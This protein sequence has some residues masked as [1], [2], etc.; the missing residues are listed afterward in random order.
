MQGRFE[1]NVRE[2]RAFAAWPTNDNLTLIVG[3]WPCAEFEANKKDVEEN[4]LKMLQLAP[5]FAARGQAANREERF[6]GAAVANYFR[7]PF[8]PGWTL[9]GDGGYNKDFITAQGI[10]DAFRDAQLCVTALGDWFSGDLTFDV[11]MK[12]YQS[13]RDDHV[14][15]IYELTIELATLEP[16]PPA[17]QQLFAAMHGNQ[18]A[19]DGFARVNSGVTSP[20]EFFSDENIRRIFAASELRRAGLSAREEEARVPPD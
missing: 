19:M 4:F 8:G 10:S 11:A 16:P 9:V 5:Q 1:T 7:K 14:L 20:A 12:Q 17:Y 15:H 2:S 18:E 13:A 6:V 3:G